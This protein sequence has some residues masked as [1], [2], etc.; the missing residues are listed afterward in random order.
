M[1]KELEQEVINLLIDLIKD[2]LILATEIKDI[3]KELNLLK[4]KIELLED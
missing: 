2:N 1:D 3:R 4:M